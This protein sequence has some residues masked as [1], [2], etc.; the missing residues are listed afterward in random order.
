ML[1]SKEHRL[2]NNYNLYFPTDVPAPVI[3][4]DPLYLDLD[5][6]RNGLI[7][8][9]IMSATN[10]G[11]IATDNLRF[12]MPDYWENV[13]FI[14]P[15]TMNLGRLLANSTL[16]FPVEVM[17]IIRY[18]IPQGRAE[19][20]DPLNP[21]NIIFFPSIDN[22]RWSTGLDLISINAE[23]PAKPWYYRFDINSTLEFVYSYSAQTRYDF[24]YDGVDVN[25]RKVPVNIIITNNTNI[26]ETRRLFVDVPPPAVE[27]GNERR[28]GQI[29]DCANL[30][31][32]LACEA[33]WAY[34]GVGS[35][36]ASAVTKGILKSKTGKEVLEKF[37]E[38]VAAQKAGKAYEQMCNQLNT[39][40]EFFEVEII[41]GVSIDFLQSLEYLD[42]ICP[43]GG[44]II[45]SILDPCQYVCERE[46]VGGGCTD[47]ECGGEQ[48]EI[49]MPTLNF[50]DPGDCF[51]NNNN[52]IEPI[53]SCPRCGDGGGWGGGGWAGG[54]WDGEIGGGCTKIGMSSR[55]LEGCE[56]CSPS[57]LKDAFRETDNGQNV[58]QE[59]ESKITACI[60]NSQLSIKTLFP[61]ILT[62][63]IELIEVIPLLSR[64]ISC[65]LNREICYDQSELMD[66]PGLTNLFIQAKRFK[67]MIKMILLPYSGTLHWDQLAPFPMRNTYNLTQEQT[68]EEALIDALADRGGAGEYITN[69]ELDR[70]LN[71]NFTVP[72][73]LDIIHF[74]TTWNQ[75]LVFWNEG[76]FSASELPANYLDPFFDLKLAKDLTSEFLLARQRVLSEYYAGFGDAWLTA[77]EGQQFEE[78]KKLAG[79]CA[80]VRVKIEQ[81]M[82]LTRIGFEARLEI[83]NGGE[84]NLENVTGKK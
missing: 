24:V 57:D 11:F 64:V 45:D 83:S 2:T 71:L 10:V 33:A 82:T 31:V 19:L 84:S 32:C 20:R 52:N 69:S 67:S 8:S 49:C 27:L 12:W 60:T 41:P 56:E 44:D 54:G 48:I 65:Q 55:R 13:A 14:T 47:Y 72:S 73:D 74:A 36:V 25:G 34:I 77:V 15:D 80:T 81:E 35:R 42:W 4:W 43:D 62:S 61:C 1:I 39:L 66:S 37:Q 6:L 16:S 68:F 5:M 53:S 51:N 79:V 59:V 46:S 26:T 18:E 76:R 40:K 23:N 38:S 7:D 3:L 75:S 70:L 58:F 9:F 78:S 63:T 50:P 30:A 17:Q 28:L 29:E 21:N 22:A